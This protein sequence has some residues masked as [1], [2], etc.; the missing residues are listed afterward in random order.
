[1]THWPLGLLCAPTSVCNRKKRN[2]WNAVGPGWDCHVEPIPDPG[3]SRPRLDL[4]KII[5]GPQSIFAFPSF[6]LSLRRMRPLFPQTAFAGREHITI[7]SS[8]MRSRT[9]AS[10][11]P[12]LAAIHFGERF[13][14]WLFVACHV[15][16]FTLPISAGSRPLVTGIGFSRRQN[17]G[18]S[19]PDVLGRGVVLPMRT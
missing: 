7:P 12:L 5:D 18:E 13:A 19:A 4:L 16:P 1:M 14:K 11:P 8:A 9:G 15:N 6:C 10:R 2:G 17:C 3:P